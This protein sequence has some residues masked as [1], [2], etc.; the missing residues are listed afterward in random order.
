MLQMQYRQVSA[1]AEHEKHTAVSVLANN[2]RER[3]HHGTGILAKGLFNNADRL[4]KL[5]S[6]HR[7][8]DRVEVEH[9]AP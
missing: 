4:D 3:K 1:I 2:P 6:V 7:L 8:L 5:R 9:R